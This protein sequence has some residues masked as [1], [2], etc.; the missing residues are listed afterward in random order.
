VAKRIL[1][2]AGNLIGDVVMST[3]LIAH[4]A[5][6]NPEARFTIV[7][8]RAA[9]QLFEAFPQLDRV[10]PMAKAKGGRHW[11]KLLAELKGQSFDLSVDLRGSLVTWLI[12][13]QKRHVK[14]R[15]L[16]PH[17]VDDLAASIGLKTAPLSRVWLSDAAREA[18]RGWL[19]TQGRPVLVLCPGA[20]WTGKR[21]LL[22]RFAM[23]G[24][25]LVEVGG[26]LEGGRIVVVGGPDE[27]TEMAALGVAL[28]GLDVVV[29][30]PR[31]PLLH[32]AALFEGTRLFVGNDSGLMHLAAAS[33]AP[34]LGLFGP[35]DERRYGPRGAFTASVRGDGV[36][37]KAPGRA[38][39]KTHPD[40][41]GLL[42]SLS[43]ETALESALRLLKDSTQWKPPS[44]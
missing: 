25:K 37:F 40:S 13:S 33:G 22:E 21:W 19:E 35:T 2:I 5:A 11:Q 6:T 16:A 14:R 31:T 28:E 39:S 27:A 1:F 24:R 29:S 15:M 4:L 20:S 17:A 26:A 41:Q 32:A 10:V 34:T 43:V 42:D 9:A 23:L 36:D 3:G 18:A 7:C 44:I 8:G 30:D 38:T 12:A